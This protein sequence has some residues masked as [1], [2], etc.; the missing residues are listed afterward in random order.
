MRKQ[1]FSI[2]KESENENYSWNGP[3]KGEAWRILPHG[4]KPL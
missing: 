2:L 4:N 1:V 3:V